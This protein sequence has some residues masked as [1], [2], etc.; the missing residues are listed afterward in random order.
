MERNHEMMLWQYDWNSQGRSEATFKNMAR[1]VQHFHEWLEAPLQSATVG[2][3][4]AYLSHRREAVS[5][6]AAEYTWRSLRSYYAFTSSLD[7]TPSPMAKIRMPQRE[8]AAVKGVSTD[9]VKALIGAC[10]GNGVAEIRDRAIIL[11]L[12]CT[13]LRRTELAKL[14]VDDVNAEQRLLTV[15]K[16]KTGKPRIV[17]MSTEATIALVKYL[18]LRERSRYAGSPMLWL[19]KRGPINSNALRL[20]LVRRS[21]E[22][23]VHVSPHMFRRSFAI[24]FLERGGSQVSLQAICGWTSGEMV[25]RYTRHASEHLAEVEYRKLYA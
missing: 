19:G 10:K 15:T 5:K 4:L 23:G 24:N 1:E 2:D 7:D 16:S 22:A 3:C 14:T 12:A 25:Q 21:T 11:M 9:E 20:I 13:G 6:H 17:P 8:E 18:R